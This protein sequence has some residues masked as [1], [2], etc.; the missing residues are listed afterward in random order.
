VVATK[1]VALTEDHSLV[2][3]GSGRR[4][5]VRLA[6][7]VAEPESQDY[8]L[9]VHTPANDRTVALVCSIFLTYVGFHDDCSLGG[10]LTC[11]S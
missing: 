9:M 4:I 2:E 1:V 11:K 5:L 10:S 7:V 3:E 8:L 6:E